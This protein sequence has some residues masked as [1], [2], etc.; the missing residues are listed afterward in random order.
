[1]IEISAIAYCN[2][3]AGP[4]WP[5]SYVRHWALDGMGQPRAGPGWP[6][7]FCGFYFQIYKA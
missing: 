1:M 7:G 5:S 2:V 6:S 4:G 3:W